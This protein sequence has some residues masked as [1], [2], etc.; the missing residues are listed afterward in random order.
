MSALGHRGVLGGM[1]E[2]RPE[3]HTR[4]HKGET[5]LENASGDPSGNSRRIHWRSDNA[6]ENTTAWVPRSAALSSN[7]GSERDDIIVIL[8]IMIL[9]LI[10]I[11]MFII[12]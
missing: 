5:P 7:A 6:L 4:N 11:I 8:I 9:L 3:P 12:I 10:M 1:P 2:S